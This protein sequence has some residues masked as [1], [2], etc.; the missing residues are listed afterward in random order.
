[1]VGAGGASPAAGPDGRYLRRRDAG[2]QSHAGE[3]EIDGP[4]DV[5]GPGDTPSRRRIFSCRPG[6]AIDE[7]ACVTEILSRLARLAYRRPVTPD[8]LA[9]LRSFYRD[10]R[11]DGGFDAGIQAAL[12]RMLAAPDFVFR[13]EREPVDLA[14]GT[15][16]RVSDLELASRLASFLWSSIPDAQLLDVAVAGTLT[17]PGVLEQQVRRMLA[18]ARATALVDN[19]FTQWFGIMHLA[20]VARVHARLEHPA[21]GPYPRFRR[22]RCAGSS[23]VQPPSGGVT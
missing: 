20:K 15:S 1:M 11:A 4:H 23:S 8:D 12:E 22:F 3:L 21:E 6:D 19:F 10:G 13:I 9:V 18:D 14:A 7:D 5:T 17:E 2:Q 16:Y